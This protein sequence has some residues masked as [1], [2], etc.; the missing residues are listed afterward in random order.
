MINEID[1]FYEYF[2]ENF[3]TISRQYKKIQTLCERFLLI[4]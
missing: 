2:C 3:L 4:K 1:L